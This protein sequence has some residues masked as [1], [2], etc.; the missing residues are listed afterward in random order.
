[1]TKRELK[2]RFIKKMKKNILLSSF[3]IICMWKTSGSFHDET[4]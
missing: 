3:I 1:M 4:S 2:M